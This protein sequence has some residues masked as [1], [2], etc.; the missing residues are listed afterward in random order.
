MVMADNVK[1]LS[2]MEALEAE[3]A[4]LKDE[5]SKLVKQLTR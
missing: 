4:S 5:K 1:V 3:N 2:K